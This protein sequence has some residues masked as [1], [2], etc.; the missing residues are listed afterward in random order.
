MKQYELEFTAQGETEFFS[1]PGNLQGRIKTK[2]EFF[3]SSGHPLTF[4]K[5]LHGAANLYRFRI[6]DYRVIVTPK[7]KNTIVILLIL[8]VGHRREAYE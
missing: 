1:L 4:A 6:G 7:D 3:I 8:K 5:K 2:M